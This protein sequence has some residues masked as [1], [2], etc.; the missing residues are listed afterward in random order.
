MH[1]ALRIGTAFA[2]L[3]NVVAAPG[4][5]DELPVDLELVLAVDVSAS[6]RPQEQR[7]QRLGYA[8]AFRSP[9]VMAAI[10]SG[11]FAR[12]AVTFVEWA[13]P[14]HQR[15]VIPW[16]I[17]DGTASGEQVARV[18]IETPTSTGF[19]TSIAQALRFSTALFQDNGFRGTRLAIDIS[20]DGQN[21]VKPSLPVVR[22]DTLAAGVTINGLPIMLTRRSSTEAISLAGLDH[23]YRDC[24]IGGPGAFII[25]VKRSANLAHAIER[26]MLHEILSDRPNEIIPIRN[27]TP[28]DC[29]FP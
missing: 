26:K 7:L 23:Y 24:V 4:R 17:V 19:S 5:A 15:V 22:K 14:D 11:H 21:N 2:I 18:L 13:D 20:G 8:A 25:V 9:A 12:I 29:T 3:I 27:N 1:G 10:Q 28:S 16:T 6:M